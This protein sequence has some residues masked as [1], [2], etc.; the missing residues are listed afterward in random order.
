MIRKLL[1]QI[2]ILLV[3]F[4]SPVLSVADEQLTE[5]EI[6]RLE[7]VSVDGKN[8]IIQ[9][10]NSNGRYTLSCTIGAT[11]ASDPKYNDT[12]ITMCTTPTLGE[13]Y[14]VF[15]KDTHWKIADVAKNAATLE[16]FENFSV[17]YNGENIALVSK[18]KNGG[19][20]G[21]YS[22]QSWKKK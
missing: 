16:F 11:S 19:D 6:V 15:N 17:I 3:L 12:P 18:D 4:I 10:G 21:I 1:A 22:L 20:W 2:L 13:N 14:W 7:S 8:K 5:P 9:V